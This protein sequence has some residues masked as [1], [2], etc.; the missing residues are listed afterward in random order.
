MLKKTLIFLL[1]IL[2]IFSFASCDKDYS[3]QISKGTSTSKENSQTTSSTQPPVS[4]QSDPVP[5]FT[6]DWPSEILPADFP[7]LGKV[8]KVY[9]S[10]RFV[11]QVTVHW[12]IVTENQVKE[13]VDKLNAYL[14][15][16]HAWQGNFYSD[17]IKYIPGTQD[18]FIRVEIQYIPSASGEIEPEFKPQFYLEISGAGIPDDK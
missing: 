13:I 9:D 8:T 11:K 7:D 2:L 17:G 14:D 10:R 4:K 15:Y 3:E 12:N 1:I 5:T 16:D 6:D 18:E